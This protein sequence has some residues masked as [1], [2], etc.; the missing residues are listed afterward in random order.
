LLSILLIQSLKAAV[1]QLRHKL[2]PL[3]CLLVQLHMSPGEANRDFVTTE[4]KTR[5][6]AAA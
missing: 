4:G 2:T 6:V 3:N 5:P 1:Q